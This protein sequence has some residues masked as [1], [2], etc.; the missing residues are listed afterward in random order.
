MS[1]IVFI[2]IV[3]MLPFAKVGIPGNDGF[4]WDFVNYTPVTVGGALLLF[5]GWYVLSAHKWFKGPV[6]QGDEGE[7]ARIESEY[8]SS[9]AAPAP[10]SS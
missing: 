2:S 4:T 3:F 6:R 10:T 9:G 7:L 8:E 1:W 5:G